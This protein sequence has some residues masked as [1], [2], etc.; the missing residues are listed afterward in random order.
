M[1]L[2]LTLLACAPEAPAP[3]PEAAVEAS[4]KAEPKVEPQAEL[5][6]AKPKGK[7]GGEPILPTPN[8][9]GAI[10]ESDVKAAVEAQM[11][12]INGCWRARVKDV[13]GLR[14]KVLLHVV[15]NAEGGVD[16]ADPKSSSLRDPDVESCISAVVAKIQFPKRATGELAIATYPFEFPPG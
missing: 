6:G 12:A 8:V 2:L 10:S 15:I 3:S 5:D 13:P 16:R 9:V 4:P 1:W 11:D 14:G 7:I